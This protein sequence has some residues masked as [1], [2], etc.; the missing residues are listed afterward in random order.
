MVSRSRSVAAVGAV[1]VALLL[2]ACTSSP[3]A[4]R[5]R[6]TTSDAPFVGCD[7]VA[8]SGNLGGAPY[9]ILLPAKWN[10]TLLIYS[11]GYRQAQPIPPDF[12][13]VPTAAEPAPG[14]SDGSKELADALL[15]KGYALAGS[16]YAS[17]GWA[18]SDG[19]AAAEQ[20]HDFFASTVGQPYRTYL[21]GDSLGGLVTQ[22]VAED[23]PEW[24]DGVAPFCGALAGVIPNLDLALDVAYAVKLLLYPG[25]QLTGYT[26]YEDAVRTLQH[27]AKRVAAATG[28]AEGVAKLLYIAALADAPTRTQ[29]FDGRTQTSRVKATV[30]ALVTALGFGTLARYEV[31]QRFGGNPSSNLDSDYAAR[32]SPADAQLVDTVTAGAAERYTA[33][34]NAGTRVRADADARARAR[35]EGGDPQGTVTAPTITLHTAADPLVIVENESFFLHRYDRAVADG[36]APAGLVQL[37]TQAPDNYPEDPGAPYGA[38]HCNFTTQSRLAVIEL[39]DRWVRDGVYPAGPALTTAFG[40][41]SGLAPLFVPGPWPDASALTD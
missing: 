25:M 11:H 8:C 6:E 14:W 30:E 10:G 7:V 26:S 34:L 41:D 4:D 33:T 28:S 37:Y 16:A 18:V 24:V 15:A 21:W 27:A 40:P 12:A 19:V 5:V 13:P 9:Q 35:A 22:V 32:I 31:E 29:T 36:T 3:D 23:H 20:L 1:V 2:S 38:G 17:N 39:L